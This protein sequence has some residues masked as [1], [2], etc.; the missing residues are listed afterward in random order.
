MQ[1][2]TTANKQADGERNCWCNALNKA[3]QRN[4]G[5]H[6][7]NEQE[8]GQRTW[9]DRTCEDHTGLCVGHTKIGTNTATYHGTPARAQHV[10]HAP[11][12]VPHDRATRQLQAAGGGL[13]ERPTTRARQQLVGLTERNTLAVIE[14]GHN[15]KRP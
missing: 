14:N 8:Q 5:Q 13:A 15:L 11:T 1:H 10:T 7:H 3:L 4:Q 2:Y 9:Q 6:G 12:A